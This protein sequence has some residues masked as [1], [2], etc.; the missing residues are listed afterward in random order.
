MFYKLSW[1]KTFYG[2][3]NLDSLMIHT[4]FG[5]LQQSSSPAAKDVAQKGWWPVP[6][7]RSPHTGSHRESPFGA[8]AVGYIYFTPSTARLR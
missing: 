5:K 2:K 1:I 3:C 8:V 6:P 4:A 7:R